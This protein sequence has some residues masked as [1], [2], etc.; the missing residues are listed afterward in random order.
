MAQV[1]D[2]L[3]IYGTLMLT[4]GHPMALRLA[5]QSRVLGPAMAAGR[6][7]DLGA[8]PGAVAS[9]TI[10]DRVHGFVVKLNHPARTLR[11]IDVYE[12][13]GADDPE[14]RA[15]ERVIAPVRLMSGRQLHAWIYYYRGA[16][17]R[18]RQLSSG[19]YA[20]RKPLRRLS[21]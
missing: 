12:G 15:F 10:A 18:A 6:L 4:S 19:R 2:C 17:A 8:Y 3:F 5:S 20:P 7:Y 11:W 21:S 13:A 9:N 14:P 1:I 16:L